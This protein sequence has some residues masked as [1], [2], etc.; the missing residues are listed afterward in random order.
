V[1]FHQPAPQP[2]PGKLSAE[3]L[4]ALREKRSSQRF[5][6]GGMLFQNGS[7]S[8]GVYL[9]EAGEVHV[10][11]PIGQWQG[12]LLEVGGPGT[13]LGL[14][15][16]MT[17]E[18]HRITAVASVPTVAVYTPREEFLSLLREHNEFS[19]EIVRLLSEDLHA[20]YHEFRSISAHPGRPR[21]RPLHEQLN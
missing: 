16:T 19:M 6:E 11:L 5:A 3:L 21:Y 20:L 8:A 10:L 13:V 15:E 17:G 2:T 7:P 4:Q 1:S 14:S 18:C 12:Q 9:V